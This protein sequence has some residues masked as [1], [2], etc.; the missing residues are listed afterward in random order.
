MSS[1]SGWTFQ[2]S[3]K[4]GVTGGELDWQIKR[5]GSNDVA[6]YDLGATLSDTAWVMRFKLTVDSST[7][8]SGSN[9][10]GYVGIGDTSGGQATSQ[11]FIGWSFASSDDEQTVV[12]KNGATL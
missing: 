10:I 8:S 4:I 9:V 1:T 12:H 2:D 11:D 6:E 3:G 5:D 7:H